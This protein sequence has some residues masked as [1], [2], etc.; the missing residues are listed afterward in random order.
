MKP[1]IRYWQNSGLVKF[2]GVRLLHAPS[3]RAALAAMIDRACAVAKA[4]GVWRFGDK[5]E[6]AILHCQAVMARPDGPTL[7]EEATWSEVSHTP[8]ETHAFADWAISNLLDA[9]RVAASLTTPGFTGCYGISP[10]IVVMLLEWFLGDLL[11]ERL[12]SPAYACRA[13]RD[14]ARAIFG[15]WVEII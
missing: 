4:A 15:A 14:E 2:A 9:A 11:S 7:A 3:Q 10:E 12:N 8:R 1:S 5:K 6:A 13:Y